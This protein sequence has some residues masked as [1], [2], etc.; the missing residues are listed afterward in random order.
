[1]KSTT[2]LLLEK[3]G[4]TADP[5]TSR[6]HN[7]KSGIDEQ[8]LTTIS[9][10]GSDTSKSTLIVLYTYPFATDQLFGIAAKI[11]LLI[12]TPEQVSRRLMYP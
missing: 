3:L 12:I 11:K 9:S 2:E 5:T 8:T 7:E 1:M 6:N 4:L 10:D